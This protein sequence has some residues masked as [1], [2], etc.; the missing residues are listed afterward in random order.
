MCFK[1]SVYLVQKSN[2][3]REKG[4]HLNSLFH[5]VVVTLR[6]RL[7]VGSDILTV[8]DI[9]VDVRSNHLSRLQLSDGRQS[10]RDDIVAESDECVSAKRSW[11]LI[12]IIESAEL[13]LIDIVNWFILTFGSRH[14]AGKVRARI[15]GA[16]ARRRWN[17][18]MRILKWTMKTHG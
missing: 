12:F 10:I 18:S 13:L 3:T 7:F 17:F 11:I 5:F 1:S 4:T 9:R 14:N 8:D 15:V 16:W 6:W 2:S